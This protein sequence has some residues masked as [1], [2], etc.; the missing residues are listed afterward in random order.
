[1]DPVENNQQNDEDVGLTPLQIYLR[2]SKRQSGNGMGRK[3][4]IKHLMLLI[5]KIFMVIL[6]LLIMVIWV[7]NYQIKL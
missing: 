5:L 4:N 3:K 1:M 2:N 7:R 6:M